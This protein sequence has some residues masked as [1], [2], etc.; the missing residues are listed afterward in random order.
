MAKYGYKRCSTAEDKQDVGRQLLKVESTLDEV[1]VEY[2][3]GKNEEGR[4]EFQ[5]L[6]SLVK[7]GDEIY[8]Q[9]LSRAGRNTSQLL[10]T[11]DSLM[12]R[13]I[14]V[15]FLTENMILTGDSDAG[16]MAQATTKLMLT[17]LSAVNEMLLTQISVATKQGLENAKRQGVKIGAASDAYRRNPNNPNKRSNTAAKERTKHLLEPI[18]LI[19]ACLPKPTYG[20]IASMLTERSYTLPSGKKGQWSAAQVKRV[21]ERFGYCIFKN[22]KQE[23]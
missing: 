7:Q 13:G 1:F 15:H 10:K 8:F 3:S 23:G 21:T 16:P 18:R 9:E 6:I 22:E 12:N 20:S 19:A 2:A 11:L 14:T 5:R 17:M 4:P